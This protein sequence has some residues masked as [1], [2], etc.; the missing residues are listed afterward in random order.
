[1]TTTAQE[2]LS[3]HYKKLAD[4]YDKFYG[5]QSRAKANLVKRFIPLSKDDQ[6][7]DVGGGTAQISLMLHSDLEMTHPVVCVDPIQ[8]MLDVAQKNG[9][10][11]I[12]STAENFFAS[13]PDYPLKVVLMNGC[14]HH[15]ADL[16]LVFSQL[17]KYMPEDGVCF[18]TEYPADKPLPY[19]KAA[20][21]AIA[22]YG[23]GMFKLDL[24]R[25]LIESKGLNCR[26]ISET[27]TIEIGKEFWYEAIRSR[28]AS[29]L[30]KFSDDE[31]EQGIEELEE[32]FKGTDV[33]KCDL[34]TN[35]IIVTH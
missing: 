26:M 12:Q 8:E 33:L 10:I 1:M 14:V 5:V 4:Q 6:I 7:V 11:T 27:E 2:V 3:E 24:L 13:K 15:F 19:F 30:Q 28:S 35:G 32:Q 31:L 25:T 23:K 22:S 16:D 17:A 9:A 20:L 34:A 21:Q 18:V 29:V